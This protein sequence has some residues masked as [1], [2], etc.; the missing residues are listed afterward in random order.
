MKKTIL[1]VLLIGSL[2][3]SLSYGGDYIEAQD[4]QPLTEAGDILRLTGKIESGSGNLRSGTDPI[5]VQKV[6]KTLYVTFQVNL[7]TLNVIIQGSRGVEYDSSV[8][9]NSVYSITIPLDNCPS[10]SYTIHFNNNTG[11]MYG[12]FTL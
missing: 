3:Y 9:T 6:G 12:N 7:D 4:V 1:L 2:F 10:G 5:V 8:N 11:T